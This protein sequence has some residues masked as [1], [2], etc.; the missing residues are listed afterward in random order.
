ME[1]RAWSCCTIKSEERLKSWLSSK[2]F[3]S[4]F[5]FFCSIQ[6]QFT[7][8]S[9]SG[10]GI[11]VK[12]N[13]VSVTALPTVQTCYFQLKGLFFQFQSFWKFLISILPS[14]TR[15]KAPVFEVPNIL[16]SC[17]SLCSIIVT[18]LWFVFILPLVIQEF[19]LDIC[20]NMS[21]FSKEKVT[22]NS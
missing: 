19:A 10:L 6:V 1:S 15:N 13:T 17:I 21:A 16:N 11:I 3:Q 22:C 8:D 4:L 14:S 18:A 2:T 20:F 7:D 12:D 5:N 9:S